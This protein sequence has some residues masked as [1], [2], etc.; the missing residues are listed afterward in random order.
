MY[1]CNLLFWIQSRR[2]YNLLK[3][4]KCTPPSHQL[5]QNYAGTTAKVQR[6]KTHVWT[7]ARVNKVD[8]V[9]EKLSWRALSCLGMLQLDQIWYP[10]AT[11]MLLVLFPWGPQNSHNHALIIFCNC[12]PWRT[13]ANTQHI[14]S[15][16]SKERKYHCFISPLSL[17]IPPPS[18]WCQDKSQG[19]VHAEQVFS[20]W[21]ITPALFLL[22]ISL[23]PLPYIYWFKDENLTTILKTS[24]ILKLLSYFFLHRK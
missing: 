10:S 9:Q 22:F 11:C 12:W 1:I 6:E 18:L 17:F 16:D 23:H 4:L 14:L 24:S 15:T 8:V 7:N 19:L 21:A 5:E 20:H 13:K 2:D 3:R